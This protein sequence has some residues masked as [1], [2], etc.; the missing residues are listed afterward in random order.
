MT[1]SFSSLEL[2]DISFELFQI[3]KTHG[4]SN[5]L[6]SFYGVDMKVQSS[7]EASNTAEGSKTDHCRS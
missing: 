6:W 2:Y 1:F 5:F 7:K 3:K 4:L